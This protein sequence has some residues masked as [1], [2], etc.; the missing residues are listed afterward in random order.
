MT[1]K[2][3]YKFGH[4]NCYSYFKSVGHGYEVGFYFGNETAFVGNFIHMSEAKDYWT[5]LNTEFKSFAK[6]YWA[7]PETSFAWYSKF[8]TNHIYK[9]YYSY[10]DTKFSVYK[11]SYT[12]KFKKYETDYKRKA[13]TWDK[14][15]RYQVRS[16]AA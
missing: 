13:K 14:H 4:Y 7:G 5:R 1:Q 15:D 6:K 11:K 12:T 3:H 16:R 10:L 8:F 9:H 2:K